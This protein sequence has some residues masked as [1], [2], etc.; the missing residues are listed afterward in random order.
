MRFNLQAR[1]YCN[2]AGSESDGKSELCLFRSSPTLLQ[3]GA[4]ITRIKRVVKTAGLPIINGMALRSRVAFWWKY[5][6]PSK[7]KTKPDTA[8][9]IAGKIDSDW[10][11]GYL[12]KVCK[13]C[14]GTSMKEVIAQYCVCLRSHWDPSHF[15]DLI[16]WRRHRIPVWLVGPFP[17]AYGLYAISAFHSRW[18]C[19]HT[20]LPAPKVNGSACAATLPY[21]VYW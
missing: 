10:P 6:R 2:T 12:T 13:A 16:K 11:A 3:A 21:Q 15:Q 5:Y 18:I 17:H 4:K 20:D 1:V 14:K 9:S 19:T 7:D 8:R